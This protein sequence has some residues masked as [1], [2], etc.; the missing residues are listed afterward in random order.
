MVEK[1]ENQQAFDEEFG[2]ILE[3]NELEDLLKQTELNE[4]A[5]SAIVE[6]YQGGIERGV[7]SRENAKDW[8]YETLGKYGA[9]EKEIKEILMKYGKE[10]R[11]EGGK[12]EKNIY[13]HPEI[14]K[15][16]EG[17]RRKIDFIKNQQKEKDKE[18]NN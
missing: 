11:I 1:F 3:A 10:K 9:G 18:N 7:V 6:A 2:K 17:L 4:T 16:S 14:K 12:D 5:I 8:L 15:Y 13:I